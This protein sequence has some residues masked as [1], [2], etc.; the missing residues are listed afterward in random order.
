MD[1]DQLADAVVCYSDS[2]IGLPLLVSY[3]LGK[4]A[5]RRPRRLFEKREEYME[6]L[7]KAY[8]AARDFRDERARA[9]ELP[10]VGDSGGS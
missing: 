8:R 3:A 4:R 9:A 10:G 2:T 6:R 1:P 7:K 5:P